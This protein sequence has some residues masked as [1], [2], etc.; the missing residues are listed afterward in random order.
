MPYYEY[1]PACAFP[2]A[3]RPLPRESYDVDPSTGG[4]IR[5]MRFGAVDT[6]LGSLEV[7]WL[8]EYSGGVFLPFRD[9]TSGKT[10]HGSGRYL[11]HTAK[12]ADLGS[13]V[14]NLTLHFKLALYPS[15]GTY[16]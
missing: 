1:D 14:D 15:V 9:A 13:R 3:A 10:T 11:L 4:V 7:L 12:G 2:A 5:F 8:D 6:P 16:T